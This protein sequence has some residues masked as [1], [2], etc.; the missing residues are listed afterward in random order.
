MTWLHKLLRKGDRVLDL[1]AGLGVTSTVAAKFPGVVSVTS[2]EANPNSID[3]IRGVHELNNVTVDLRHGMLVPEGAGKPR[4]FP[5]H[6]HIIASSEFRTGEK[7]TTKVEIPTHSIQDLI[8]DLKPTFLCCDI[9]G[10]EFGLLKGQDLSS[11]RVIV[12]EMHP[13]IIGADK[14]RALRKQFEKA[15][16]MKNVKLSKHD[17]HVYER[18]EQN[19]VMKAVKALK[20]VKA[21]WS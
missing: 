20:Q 2:F 15:G 5:V 19:P 18:G 12:I 14:V 3:Y 1:G 4:L 10:S 9:E 8:A 11:I 6:E 21:L 17:V 13:G 16:I 7:A